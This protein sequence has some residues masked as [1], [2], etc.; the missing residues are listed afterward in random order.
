MK[1]HLGKDNMD[2][3]QKILIVDDEPINLDFFDV[4]LSKLGFVVEKAEDGEEALEK[5]KE[6][7]P[8]LI[9]LD[10][11]MPKISGWEV[12]RIIKTSD[13]Y[14]EYKEIPIIMF[15]A[16]DDVQDKIEGFGLGVEDYITKP[17]N[18]SEVLARIKAVLRNREIAKQ[19]LRKERRLAAFDSLNKSLIYF[20]KHLKEPVNTVL[21]AAKDVDLD[22]KKGLEDFVQKVI[23]ESEVTLATLD[24]L[25]DEVKELEQAEELDA[26]GDQILKD[27]EEKFQ[28]HFLL[29]KERQAN[30]NEV[31]G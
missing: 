26:K 10:N 3:K 5:L 11:I 24:G 8:D 4:M 2:V 7:N 12:T 31:S 27:L 17:F 1:Y 9:I 13:E 19:L 14:K 6:S 20:T 18:F 21:K 29:W 23:K 25:E 22:N 30:L 15:S 16:M 28:K